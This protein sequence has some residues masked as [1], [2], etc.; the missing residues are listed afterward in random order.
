MLRELRDAI[1][2]FDEHD[3]RVYA[4]S[5]DDQEALA[6]FSEKQSLPFPLLS[7]IDSE[8][9]RKFGILNEQVTKNDGLLYGIP[10]PGVYVIDEQGFVT[11]KFFHDSYKK[12]DSAE[13]Y[14]DAALGRLTVDDSAPQASGGDEQIRLTVAV[15]GGKGTIRQGV[16]RQLVVRFELPEGLHIYG[17]PVPEGMV[18][19]D[20]T[21]DGPEGLRTM[22]PVFPPTEPLDLP[23]A[24][25]LNVWHG[26]VD[27]IYPF[28]ATGELVSEC[29]PLDTPSVE[30]EATVRYQACTDSEC[31]L[32]KTETFTL[33][34]DLDVIDIPDIEL[35][36]GH[37]QRVGNYDGTPALKRLLARKLR[38]NPQR[39]PVFVG[40]N[41]WLQL[42][43]LGRKLLG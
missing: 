8:V 25:T 21:V 11:A 27:L 2:K 37:G 38:E 35:H 18:A 23:G 39:A 16:I 34:L 29:R 1:S 12:R 6:E 43:A 32:P 4:I 24:A 10:Y 17:P 33:S 3:V 42:K 7:D 28:Y 13:L 20:V 22:A 31:L 40:K 36:R 30:I 41:V 19:T 26:T 9:I 5:Y 14:L 15:H